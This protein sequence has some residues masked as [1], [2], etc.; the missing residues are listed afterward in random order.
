MSCTWMSQA[1]GSQYKFDP[2]LYARS[3]TVPALL[4]SVVGQE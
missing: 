1:L 4:K 3:K 2:S